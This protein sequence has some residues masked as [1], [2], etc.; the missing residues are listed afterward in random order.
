MQS[1]PEENSKTIR[2]LETDRDQSLPADYENSQII[3]FEPEVYDERSYLIISQ[4]SPGI[5]KRSRKRS[6]AAVTESPIVVASA[7]DKARSYMALKITDDMFKGGVEQSNPLNED[8]PVVEGIENGSSSYS[9]STFH[10][11]QVDSMRSSNM[12]TTTE[13]K[14]SEETNRQPEKVFRRRLSEI[15]EIS[16]TNVSS[17]IDKEISNSSSSRSIPKSESIE[18]SKDSHNYD[19]GNFE[20]F[21]T[22]LSPL[23]G[24]KNSEILN[25]GDSGLKNLSY[26]NNTRMKRRAD[27]FETPEPHRKLTVLLAAD[28]LEDESQIDLAVHGELAG[29]IVERIFEEVQ[30]NE[31]LKVALGPGLYRKHKPQESM[32]LDKMYRQGLDE[33]EASF[34]FIFFSKLFQNFFSAF[35][36]GTD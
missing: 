2:D 21:S 22:T 5:E 16:H 23:F 36:V 33:D 31:G 9:S 24:N 35:F 32:A 13:W 3:D 30:R 18:K 14:L 17:S 12:K 34:V 15:S 11:S 19:F 25:V 26:N 10:D 28:N 20:N 8:K 7:A 6:I 27:A 29:K 4:D 1:S